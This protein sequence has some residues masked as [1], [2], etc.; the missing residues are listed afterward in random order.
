MSKPPQPGDCVHCGRYFRVLEWDHVFPKSW[1]PDTTPENLEK[2]EIP[3][4]K[5]C[6]KEYGILE[7]DL[8]VRLGLCL[9]PKDYKSAGI[10]EKALRALNPDFAKNA[11]DRRLREA[12][13]RKILREAMQGDQIPKEGFYP[14]FDKPTG[15]LGQSPVAIGIN[16]D[17]VH[18]LAVKVVKGITH[19]EDGVIIKE[20]YRV[21]SFVLKD[22][23]AQPFMLALLRFGK[24]YAREPGITV[25]RGVADDDR[26]TSIFSVEIWG[27]FKFYAH[28]GKD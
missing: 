24:I 19:I 1:Y 17:S 21:Q 6:N 27:R 5:P 22:A 13:R 9:D 11:R 25:Y 20:P 10:A 2:W 4:C 14:N 3:S 15:W 26:Q 18:K 7:E 28:V 12:K 16:P 8:L 23:E